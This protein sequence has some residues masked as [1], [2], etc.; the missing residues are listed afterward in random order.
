MTVSEQGP[1]IKA[2]RRL[3]KGRESSAALVVET[4]SEAV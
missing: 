1:M 2:A 3:G 4:A